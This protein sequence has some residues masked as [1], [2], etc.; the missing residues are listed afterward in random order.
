MIPRD[1]TN[2]TIEELKAE[3]LRL[4]GERHQI[5]QERVEEYPDDLDYLASAVFEI[6]EQMKVVE[7]L[8]YEKMGL[9]K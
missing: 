5:I 2:F 1:Y 6:E 8:I 9:T 7:D 3:T 4:V